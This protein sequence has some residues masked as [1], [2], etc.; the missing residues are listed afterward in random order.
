MPEIPKLTLPETLMLACDGTSASGLE[1]LDQA[2]QKHIPQ[3]DFQSTESDDLS[4]PSQKNCMCDSVVRRVVMGLLLHSPEKD[5]Q[6][7]QTNSSDEPAVK[8]IFFPCTSLISILEI[9]HAPSKLHL[10]SHISFFTTNVIHKIC[11]FCS[12]HKH[13]LNQEPCFPA[14]TKFVCSKKGGEEEDQQQQ[15]LPMLDPFPRRRVRRLHQAHNRHIV[16]FGENLRL[17]HAH[18]HE[19]AFLPV[20]L[21][22]LLLRNPHFAH[23]ERP[24]EAKEGKES[25]AQA[26]RESSQGKKRQ[27]DS[28]LASLSSRAPGSRE[29]SL[30]TQLEHNCCG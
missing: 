26:L 19:I 12:T 10:S 2:P 18:D 30:D 28:S 23:S 20:L 11:V 15:I 8:C 6:K 16:H 9:P 22:V 1:N 29:S 13:L 25:D 27:P 14:T 4:S 21:G 17:L 24:V 3:A 5:R 7:N